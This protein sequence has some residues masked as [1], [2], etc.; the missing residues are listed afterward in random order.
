LRDNYWLAALIVTVDR[1]CGGRLV[2]EAG[3]RSALAQ[4]ARPDQTVATLKEDKEWLKQQL[5]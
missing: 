4:T 2:R 3:S 1:R 5:T